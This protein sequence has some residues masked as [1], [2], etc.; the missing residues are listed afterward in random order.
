MAD[1]SQ[2]HSWGYSG[3]GNENYWPS[4]CLTG[5]K[6]SPINIDDKDLQY[7]VMSNVQF[8]GY[9]PNQQYE[10]VNNGHTV[11]VS[12]ANSTE[13]ITGSI[14]GQEKLYLEGFHF[15]WGSKIY[16]GSE[17]TINSERFS[18]EKHAVYKSRENGKQAVVSTLYRAAQDYGYHNE[19]LKKI[20]DTIQEQLT[21][22]RNYSGRMN[23]THKQMRH[24]QTLDKKLEMGEYCTYVGSFTTPPCTEGIIWFINNIIPHIPNDYVERLRKIKL[25]SGCKGPNCHAATPE[26]NFRT[27]KLLNG[28]N[29]TCNAKYQPL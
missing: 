22:K 2:E 19:V 23:F 11:K 14:L 4:L 12:F 7:K 26:N 17:H 9:I 27:T 6:Q 25:N 5:K 10:M 13:F 21:S 18:L 3:L 28:R 16:M 29:V 8:G 1:S 20:L 24:F 15:H